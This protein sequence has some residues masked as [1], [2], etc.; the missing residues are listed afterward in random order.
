[1]KNLIRA[2]VIALFIITVSVFLVI[3]INKDTNEKNP[4]EKD[5]KIYIENGAIYEKT[6][7]VNIG[8][9]ENN[10][11][12]INKL[13]EKYLGDM[14]IYFSIIPDK[15]YYLKANGSNVSETDFGNLENE[16]K[17]KLAKNMKYFSISDTLVLD[18]FYKTDMHWKQEDLGKTVEKIEKELGIKTK[19][20]SYEEQTLGEFYGTYYKDASN[21]ENIKLAENVKPDELIYLSNKEL[22]N[23]KVYNGETEEEEKIYNLDRVN[24]TKNKYDL[25]LSGATALT[26]ITN[27]DAKTDKK[28]I[29]F[30][31]SFGSSIA[32]LLAKDYKEIILVD[33]RYINSTILENY[34]D[35]EKYKDADVL[36]LYSSRVINQSGIFR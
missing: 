4:E 14:N 16:V 6:G 2:I 21:L 31:D 27:E 5:E 10:I 32:P 24:E 36:F 22:E 17:S 19:K 35:F 13:C 28:L 7:D 20:V 3:M 12:K 29:L 18:N 9:I 11:G 34:I 30:R 25:Y 8:A 26:T 15:E 33:I 23:C 1:M